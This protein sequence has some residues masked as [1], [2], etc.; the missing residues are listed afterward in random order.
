MLGAN[1]KKIV[2]N[3]NNKVDKI[4]KN[5]SK[6]KELKNNQS[7]NLTYI[8]NI[9]AMKKSIFLI[10]N[11]NKIFNCLKQIFIKAFIFQYFN[12]KCYI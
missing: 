2:Q 7:N 11:I 12:L 5:L 8:S 1:N 9:K 4:V 10:F 6:F 3:D